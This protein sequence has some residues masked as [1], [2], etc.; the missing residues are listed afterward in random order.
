MTKAS[1]CPDYSAFTDSIHIPFTSK[2]EAGKTPAIAVKV[3]GIEIDHPG[4]DT[5]STIFALSEEY[6]P[7]F[8]EVENP[9]TLKS[10]FVEYTS[11]VKWTGRWLKV[12]VEFEG[13]GEGGIGKVT[14]KS[15]IDV[16]VVTEQF[17]R[18]KPVEKEDYEPVHY[19]GIGFGHVI[20]AESPYTP[21]KNAVLAIS[22]YNG[23][24]VNKDT[25]T[26][27]YILRSRSIE[28]GITAKNTED[29]KC[30]KLTNIQSPG[31]PWYW[32]RVNFALHIKDH[33]GK[34]NGWMPGT[35]LLDTGLTKMNI[36]SPHYVDNP[37]VPEKEKPGPLEI[38]M[39]F[40]CEQTD[41]P[42][43]SFSWPGKG[44][45]WLP[46]RI[47]YHVNYGKGAFANTGQNFYNKFD[48]MF[49]A[50]EGYWGIRESKPE[51][52]TYTKTLSIRHCPEGD[53][54]VYYTRST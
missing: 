4:L 23:K 36:G 21:D 17:Y 15:E 49:D 44:E 34:D 51:L 1:G 52:R 5:G 29:F 14:A 16:L 26:P 50:K 31:I 48:A 11:G 3:N 18:D 46:S 19:M 37:D 53:Y 12:S 32:D 47:E 27:G 2:D 8:A 39:R 25:F 40:P 10:G 33:T 20:E 9:E 6:V 54:H 43:Y 24:P 41:L 38:A 28:I 13:T 45:A 35:A 7:A 22:H 42:E 30:T